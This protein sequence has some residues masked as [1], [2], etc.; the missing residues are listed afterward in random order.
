MEVLKERQGRYECGLP[1]DPL[2][3]PSEQ[4]G[5]KPWSNAIKQMCSGP[6]LTRWQMHFHPEIAP[7][8]AHEGVYFWLFYHFLGPEAADE[9]NIQ[10][11][12]QY[13]FVPL[14]NPVDFPG[15]HERLMKE[16]SRSKGITFTYT[17]KGSDL[18]KPLSCRI[19]QLAQE[20]FLALLMM[21]SLLVVTGHFAQHFYLKHY[22]RKE[23]LKLIRLHSQQAGDTAVSRGIPTES[24]YN[25]LCHRVARGGTI[26]RLLL[27]NRLTVE[28]VED[29]CQELLWNPE[30]G[31][32]SYRLHESN[33]WWAEDTTS[34]FPAESEAAEENKQSVWN[35]IGPTV[36]MAQNSEAAN[37]PSLGAHIPQWERES[38]HTRESGSNP[39]YS[40][41]YGDSPPRGHLWKQDSLDS[42]ADYFATSN[43]GERMAIKM[44]ENGA[45]E[46]MKPAK[47]LD[48]YLGLMREL[49]ELRRASHAISGELS[50]DRHLRSPNM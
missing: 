6:G 23:V 22:I 41:R 20:H 4:L 26:P 25:L 21:L 12:R 46:G 40:W 2:F 39:L 38:P 15:L 1:L 11:E 3:S 14:A 9:L 5:G 7:A 43:A 31:V 8:I 18:R 49:R 42:A 50:R 37:S 29:A 16:Q 28:L 48:D 17:Y 30:T 13:L 45:S 34:S 44:Y 10:V 32:H 19:S 27:R 47:G 35:S 24:I 33:H 36:G